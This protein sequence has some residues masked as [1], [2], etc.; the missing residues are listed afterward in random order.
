M[1][2]RQVGQG[3][4]G[5]RVRIEKLRAHVALRVRTLVLLILLV[6]LGLLVLLFGRWNM[7]KP[8]ATPSDKRTVGG[9]H[10]C[11]R[12]VPLETLKQSRGFDSRA[13]RTAMICRIF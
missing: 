12:V 13:A 8:S 10:R 1:G 9:L 4:A 6:L 11:R 5:G 7:S 3:R 2:W